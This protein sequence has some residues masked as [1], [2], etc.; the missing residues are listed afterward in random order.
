MSTPPA[1]AYQQMH[2][3]F[4]Q[5]Q[6]DSSDEPPSKS[7]T[8]EQLLVWDQRQREILGGTYPR[9]SGR[10]GAAALLSITPTHAA[11]PA[12]TAIAAARRK[13][14]SDSP[15]TQPPKRVPP[16]VRPS[17]APPPGEKA[18]SKAAPPDFSE[19][20]RLG[21]VLPDELLGPYVLSRYHKVW[22]GA[23][24]G[25]FDDAAWKE[26][27]DS[28][29][30]KMKMWA[31]L[32]AVDWDDPDAPDP[33]F[34]LQYCNH[35]GLEV[36]MQQLR[37]RIVEAQKEMVR[38]YTAALERAMAKPGAAAAFEKIKK[39]KERRSK[40]HQPGGKK[41]DILGLFEGA[42]G[43]IGELWAY[44][45]EVREA[46]GERDAGLSWGIKKTQ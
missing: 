32:A 4:S 18:S 9:L 40:E 10:Y 28:N 24:R 25:F 13:L 39:L 8:T 37:P 6:P 33:D 5:Q 15:L 26:W 3:S 36:D 12:S 38:V 14:N 31:S 16:V 41:L 35:A 19:L 42:L 20:I 44:G 27:F 29:L 45:L 1:T 34:A 2:D 22:R 43:A 30:E 46:S 23:T 17:A 7:M 11:H 21:L